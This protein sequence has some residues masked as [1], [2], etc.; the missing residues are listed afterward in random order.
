MRKKHFMPDNF[1]FSD[2]HREQVKTE[3]NIDDKEVDRILT[4]IGEWEFNS[5]RS[6]WGR[7]C[8]RW[9]RTSNERN[10]LR[11]PRT[12]STTKAQPLSKDERADDQRKFE[13]HMAKLGVKT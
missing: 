1:V 8:L 4:L 9:F 2:K 12:Y 13:E 3:F 11:R 7:V 10:E 6:D 5:P